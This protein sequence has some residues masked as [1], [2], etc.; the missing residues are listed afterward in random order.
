MGC[1]EEILPLL[2]EA[3]IPLSAVPAA[4]V[5]SF[6]LEGA[7]TGSTLRRD[8]LWILMKDALP[9][10]V[11]FGEFELDLQSGEL[12][13]EGSGVF[14]QD[15]PFKVLRMLVE[16]DGQIVGRKEIRNKLWPNDTI[17]EFDHSI[18][19]AIGNLRRALGDNAER[20]KFVQTIARRGYR[21]MVPVEWI[22]SAD[23]SVEIASRLPGEAAAVS[24][25]EAAVAGLTGRAVSHYRVLNIIGGGGMGVVYRAE[26][27][28]LGRQVALKFLPEEMGSDPL[29]LERFSREARAASLLD[30]PNICHIYE[31][32]EHEGQP[33]IVMQLLE[34]Q[35]LRDRLAAVA[36]G[37]QLPFD[38]LL[39]I[40]IQV[41]DG[42]RAAHE[43]GII[44]RDI[45][46][47]NVFLTSDG[48]CKI[49][50]FGL[51]K[52]VEDAEE[53][54]TGT[55]TPEAPASSASATHLTRA[56]I[57]I[58]TAGYMSPE[59][60]LGENLDTR[61]DLFSFGLVLYE[62]ATGRRA[63][64][65]ETAAIVHEA[66]VHQTPAPACELN[67]EISPDLQAIIDKALEKDRE[68]RFRTAADLGREL[69]HLKSDG[70]KGRRHWPLL[71][72]ASL[73]ILMVGMGIA[74]LLWR[75]GKPQVELQERQI[76]ANPQGDRVTGAAVSP[77]GKYLA[78]ADQTGL[79]LRSIESGETHSVNLP[80]EL[81][82]RIFGLRWFP[83]GGKLVAGVNGS[84]GEDIW[85]IGVLGEEKPYLLYRHGFEPAIS[86]DSRMVAFTNGELTKD[87]RQVW[88]GR[89][90][91]SQPRKLADTGELESVS[92]PVWSPDGHWIAYGRSWKTP[93]GAWSSAIEVR[94]AAGGPAKTLVAESGLPKKYTFLQ[95]TDA[96]FAESWSS[97]WRLVF[98]VTETSESPTKYSLWQAR[99]DPDTAEVVG[100]PERLMEWSSFWPWNLTMTADG[101]RLSM[102]KERSWVDVYL[103]ELGPG[104]T[105][106]KSAPPPNAR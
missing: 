28:K 24:R 11:R 21:L 13:H 46:P 71:V 3:R 92:S 68:R 73:V 72:A 6:C 65:G 103:G 34:G 39:D 93:Q 69:R 29:A 96:Q 106:M 26:D 59:Q 101:K 83:E 99:V 45:K 18:N 40:A 32:G 55:E 2:K 19:V 33:F 44:H 63:F 20:P 85:V 12:R 95:G 43:Q 78:Y 66:I 27:L 70:G 35:T 31:F 50:D 84:D 81:R 90:D 89:I 47:A 16:G 56:G 75:R 62:M 77:D 100:K 57:A 86:P 51:V 64:T 91:G 61:T 14:L 54:E 104:G 79:Y 15:Q 82:G 4:L 30:H 1:Q 98:S 49:L 22:P 38:E 36:E 37:G 105:T 17:V 9:E 67:P 76:T 23:N 7:K 97:D 52:L 41:S 87:N 48:R 80:A 53:E 102:L 8:T 94:P 60:I 25:K 88:V 5:A 58:G 10:R 42:L 74:G